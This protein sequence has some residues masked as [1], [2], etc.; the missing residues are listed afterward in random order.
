MKLS[1]L[2]EFWEVHSLRFDTFKKGLAWTKKHIDT[3]TLRR[4]SNENYLVDMVVMNK[5]YKEYLMKQ[6]A[7]YE[8]RCARAKLMTQQRIDKKETTDDVDIQG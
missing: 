1:N 7:I 2:K 8:E 5:S 4:I 6:D 3:T